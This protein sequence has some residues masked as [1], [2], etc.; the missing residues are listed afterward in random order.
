MEQITLPIDREVRK[1]T[2]LCLTASEREALRELMT[3]VMVAMHH[4]AKNL[5]AETLDEEDGHDA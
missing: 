4:A 5:D 2:P 3:Q 1:K